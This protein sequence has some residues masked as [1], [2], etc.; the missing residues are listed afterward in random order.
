MNHASQ[1]LVYNKMDNE[2]V[3][4]LTSVFYITQKDCSK[5]PSK[6]VQKNGNVFILNPFEA[7][8]SVLVTEH[9]FTK[10]VP[11]Y[12]LSLEVQTGAMWKE[13]FIHN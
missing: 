13:V 1:T 2:Q 8:R 11:E 12:V 9:A 6:T 10:E 4:S 5:G 3:S 7:G